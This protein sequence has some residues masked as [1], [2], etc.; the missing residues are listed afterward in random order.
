MQSKKSVNPLFRLKKHINCVFSQPSSS[1]RMA[2]SSHRSVKPFKIKG[3]NFNV[4]YGLHLKVQPTTWFNSKMVLL[5]TM[6]T[7]LP[8]LW[9][10]NNS[11][12]SISS[13]SDNSLLHKTPITGVIISNVP[14]SSTTN[15]SISL[16]DITTPLPSHLRVSVHAKVE[17][18]FA[19]AVKKMGLSDHQLSQLSQ[20]FKGTIDL[21]ND[22]K[23]GD[24]LTVIYEQHKFK[25]GVEERL[26]LAAEVA[27]QDQ[28]YRAL[29][30]TNVAGD[31]GYYTPTGDSLHKISLFRAPLEDFTRISSPFGKRRHPISRR[32]HFHTGTDYAAKWGTP[33]FAG[34]DA[35]V[36]FVGRKGGYGKVVILE[37]SQRV[38]TLYAHLAKFFTDISVG[39][40]VIKGQIIA[41]V[42]RSGRATG[43]HLHYEIRMDDEPQ[44]PEEMELPLITPIA[45]EDRAYFMSKTRQLMA[46]LNDLNQTTTLTRVVEKIHVSPKIVKSASLISILKQHLIQ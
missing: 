28:V 17:T 36:Q 45:E 4:E 16:P 12:A 2:R 24:Q 25:E 41:Y 30:Y 27:T 42:G 46:Q 38:T 39:D 18:S 26:M 6:L 13:V 14:T 40:E 33:V 20:I 23:S 1:N 22:I 34:G 43:P 7:T 8:L 19:I 35:T 21:G 11:S 10:L 9:W 15:P 31:T 3:N 29:R 32:T 37:H 44:S 5:T